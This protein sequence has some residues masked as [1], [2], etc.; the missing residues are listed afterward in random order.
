MV[1]GSLGSGPLGR[2]A[3]LPKGKY[4]VSESPSRARRELTRLTKVTLGT[5][6]IDAVVMRMSDL[7]TRLRRV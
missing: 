2:L 7:A 5:C 4:N 6:I 3:G 1:C